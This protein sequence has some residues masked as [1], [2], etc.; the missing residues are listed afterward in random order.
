MRTPEQKKADDA[1]TQAV[2]DAVA[3][4]EYMEPGTMNVAYMVIVQQRSWP[5]DGSGSGS[6]GLVRLYKD[7]DMPWVD[8][9]GMLK[10]ASLRAEREYCDGTG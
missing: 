5:G 8:M 6:T 1:L 9:L 3:A 7:G 10:A 2:E 4:Y